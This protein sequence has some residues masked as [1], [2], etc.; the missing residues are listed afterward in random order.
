MLKYDF[1]KANTY[2]G[3][4]SVL[5]YFP[6]SDHVP[7]WISAGDVE[8]G[9]IARSNEI[10]LH[11]ELSAARGSSETI[12][13][14]PPTWDGAMED[15]K[16]SLNTRLCALKG[17]LGMWKLLSKRIAHDVNL[18]SYSKSNLHT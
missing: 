10:G 7:A 4:N 8:L 2:A 15:I 9:G 3:L 14:F 17:V 5:R 6:D 12:G 1:T 11:V 16:F 18:I 13:T